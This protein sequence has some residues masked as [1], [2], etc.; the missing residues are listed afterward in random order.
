MRQETISCQKPNK[1]SVNKTAVF[2]ES[3]KAYLY[4]LPVFIVLGFFTYYAMAYNIKI[5]LYDWNGVSPDKTFVGLDNF[6]K[7]LHDGYF[8]LAIKNTLIYFLITVPV[9]AILG[10]ILANCFVNIKV[11]G[12]G[13]IK[14]V[15]FFPNVVSLVVIGTA[16]NQMYNYQN[17]FLNQTLRTLGLGKIAV[18]WTGNPKYALY[19]IIIAN[20]YTYV[21]FSMTLYITGL[22]SIP[23]EIMDA[24]KVDGANGLQIIRRILLPLLTSTHMTVLILGIVGTLKTFDI[25]WLITQGGPARKSELLATMLYRSYILEYKAGYASAISV[26]IL[27]VAVVLAGINIYIQHRKTDY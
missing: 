22:L 17:G 1:K 26:V 11:R 4:I 12:K 5:S 13:I 7:L 24:A 15:I 3:K 16:F 10:F 2:K 8:K 21:G 20:I 6:K 14:S 23:K 27:V 19:S 18:D 9:Q 25:V